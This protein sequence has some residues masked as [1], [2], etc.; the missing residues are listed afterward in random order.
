MTR[1]Q[2]IARA[3]PALLAIET[4]HPRFAHRVHAGSIIIT[5]NHGYE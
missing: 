1:W 3:H 4:L 2:E 5:V